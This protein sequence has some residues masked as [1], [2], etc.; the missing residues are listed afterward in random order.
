M[1]SA[2]QFAFTSTTVT[3][4]EHGSGRVSAGWGGMRRRGGGCR[5]AAQSPWQARV[6]PALPRGTRECACGR[7]PAAL[8]GPKGGTNGRMIHSVTMPN[9]APPPRTAQ[10]RSLQVVGG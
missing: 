7:R 4:G 2:V 5:E 8:T 9:E 3:C 6:L 1:F 10:K